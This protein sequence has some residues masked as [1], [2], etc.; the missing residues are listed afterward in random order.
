MVDLVLA[1]EVFYFWN[2]GRSSMDYFLNFAPKTLGTL[3]LFE[4]PGT[5]NLLTILFYRFFPNFKD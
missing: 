1:Y 4:L 3:N 5:K 2:R